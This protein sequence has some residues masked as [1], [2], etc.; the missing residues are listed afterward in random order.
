MVSCEG[1]CVGDA[2]VACAVHGGADSGVVVGGADGGA[3][4]AALVLCRVVLAS[5]VCRWSGAGGSGAGRGAAAPG[6]ALVVGV[7]VVLAL[8]LLQGEEGRNDP[9][10][11]F[12]HLREGLLHEAARM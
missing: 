11:G 5:L 1:S 4:A 12:G 6:A 9:A 7:E 8:V 10:V 3:A 2:G